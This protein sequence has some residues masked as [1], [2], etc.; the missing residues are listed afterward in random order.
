MKKSLDNLTLETPQ[1]FTQ[2]PA[3]ERNLEL[4]VNCVARGV[5]SSYV[6]RYR[7]PKRRFSDDCT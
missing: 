5:A 7:Q 4:V 1:D 2:L 3:Q 6:I